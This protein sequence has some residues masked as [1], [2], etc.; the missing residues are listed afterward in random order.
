MALLA[1]GL[2]IYEH[3]QT[4]Q[5]IPLSDY[6]VL[7]NKADSLSHVNCVLERKIEQSHSESQHLIK[8]MMFQ[9]ASQNNKATQKQTSSK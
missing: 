2:G 4:D 3:Q 7:K 6:L 8:M 5:R 1:A 9:L